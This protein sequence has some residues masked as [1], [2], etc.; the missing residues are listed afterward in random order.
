METLIVYVFIT[1]LDHCASVAFVPH[2]LDCS[3]SSTSCCFIDNCGGV[4]LF[5]HMSGEQCFDVCPGVCCKHP[6]LFLAGG[7]MLL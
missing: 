2:M 4:E 3:V 1:Y 7:H 6:V 5:W